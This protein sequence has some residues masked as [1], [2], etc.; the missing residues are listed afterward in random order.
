MSFVTFYAGITGRRRFV[1][2][3]AGF[4]IMGAYRDANV[5]IRGDLPHGDGIRGMNIPFSREKIGS[6]RLTIYS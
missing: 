4:D 5:S 3:F 6:R 1:N 2:V